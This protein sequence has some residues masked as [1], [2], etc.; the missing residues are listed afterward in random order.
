[1]VFAKLV[2]ASPHS[3][4]A[5]L[6]FAAA[7]ARNLIASNKLIV[8]ELATSLV[9]WRKLTGDQITQIV[10]DALVQQDLEAERKR[11]ADWAKTVASARTFML[12]GEP[13]G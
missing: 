5:F 7:E 11:R 8:L 6:E 4:E 2:C 1:L 10:A 9:E 13:G 3:V 12:M